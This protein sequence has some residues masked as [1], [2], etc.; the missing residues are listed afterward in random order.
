MAWKFFS[1]ILVVLFFHFMMRCIENLHSGT[2]LCATNR[3]RHMLRTVIHEQL[4][5]WEFV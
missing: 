2:F 4:A 3:Q 1:G 5:K